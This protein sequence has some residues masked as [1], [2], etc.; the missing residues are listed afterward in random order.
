[1]IQ[2]KQQLRLDVC[3]SHYRQDDRDPV[4]CLGQVNRKVAARNV[5]SLRMIQQK[6]Q[7]LQAKV[8]QIHLD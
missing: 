2:Q 7:T 3:A 1:M 6:Q 5:L 8:I 4:G